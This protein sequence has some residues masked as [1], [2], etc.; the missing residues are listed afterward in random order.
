VPVKDFDPPQ[1]W[2]EAIKD[3]SG[4]S[5]D[6]FKRHARNFLDCIKSRKQPISDLASGHRVAT[7]CH[8]ANISLRTHR[9]IVWDGQKEEIVGDAESAKML[10]RPYRGSW[11]AELQRLLKG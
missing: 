9:G 5:R 3:E 7:I 1:F 2:T 4:D 6:Q 11:D 10:L 8:L